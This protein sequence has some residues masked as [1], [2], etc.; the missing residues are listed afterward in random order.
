[1]HRELAAK[2]ATFDDRDV[3]QQWLRF[4]GSF[5]QYSFSN[6]CLILMAKPDAT[7]VAG[8]R[9]WQTKGHQVRRGE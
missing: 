4:A 8:Y 9:A 6:T 1:M 5:H 2:L 7:L 3:W